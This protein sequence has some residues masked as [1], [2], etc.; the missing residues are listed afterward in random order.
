MIKSISGFF[1]RRGFSPRDKGRDVI[2]QAQSGTGETS[3]CSYC[4]VQALI[5]S[6]TRD[7][8]T[9]AEKVILVIGNYMNIQAHLVLE[10][11]VCLISAT[12]SHELLEITSKFMAEPVR[13]LVK[14]DEWTLEVSQNFVA[15]EKEEWKFDTL[16]NLYETLTIS[17]CY[18]FLLFNAWRH[19]SEG[20]RCN[21]RSGDTRV[22]ITTD[23][24]AC[25]IDVQQILRYIEQYYSTQIDEMPMNMADI[26]QM[27]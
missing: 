27:V 16:C 10:V 7:L 24:W 20:A 8:A 12:H 23:V 17:S 9:Q 2:A 22:L 14:R 18:I 6:P 11:K 19:A 26:L 25:G 15:I 21:H 4:L 13:I 3:N 1:H 5:L